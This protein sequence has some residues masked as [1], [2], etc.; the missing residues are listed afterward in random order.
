[1]ILS[2]R[3]YVILSNDHRRPRLP[4]HHHTHTT[5]RPTPKGK[6]RESGA[7]VRKVEFHPYSIIIFFFI[8]III[9]PL[10]AVTCSARDPFP[11]PSPLLSYTTPIPLNLI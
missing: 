6:E 1:M 5:W 7:G 8:I 10:K 9:S 3:S 11:S 4:S 2:T